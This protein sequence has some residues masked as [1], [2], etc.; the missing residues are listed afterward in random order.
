LT[1]IHIHSQV[2]WPLDHAYVESLNDIRRVSV[3]NLFGLS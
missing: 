2:R 3:T 1:K